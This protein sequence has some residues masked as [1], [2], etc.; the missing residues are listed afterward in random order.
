MTVNAGYPDLGE[1]DTY[2]A[3][4]PDEVAG[5]V[6]TGAHVDT[7]SDVVPTHTGEDVF[8]HGG[9]LKEPRHHGEGEHVGPESVNALIHKAVADSRSDDERKPVRDTP[10]DWRTGSVILRDGNPVRLVPTNR[11]RSS[12]VLT[13]Q[14]ASAIIYIGRD[15]GATPEAPDVC[16]L[17]AG[18]ARTF[19]H[20][21]EIW[22]VGAQGDVV[23][24]VEE[25]YA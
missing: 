13:N 21:K 19:S 16:Y 20:P 23:D 15:A 25:N 7:A 5:Y 2:D 4:Y 24:F 14:S 18:A 8:F 12:I 10:D 6:E 11:K 22:I 3:G 17:P 9:Q 1:L